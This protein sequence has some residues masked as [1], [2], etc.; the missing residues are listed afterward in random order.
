M[1]DRN[2]ASVTE[3][4]NPGAAPP[5]SPPSICP[6]PVFVIGSPRSG[7]T[8]LAR[9]LAQHS[10]LWASAESD[11]LFF[12]FANGFVERGFDRAMEIPGQR[13]LRVE[14][15][16]REEFLA[17]LGIGINALMTS[18]SEGRRWLDHTPRYAL[19]V[20]TL[21][22]VFPSASFLHILRDGRE[23]VHSMLNF[24]NAVPEPSVK[25]FLREDVP[26]ATDLRAACG[27]WSEHVEAA[28]KF[29]DKHPD[30]A[31]TVRFEDLV[32]APQATFRTVHEFLGIPDEEAPTR[33]FATTRIN[34]SFDD[35]VRL[36]AGELWETW[37]DE[38]RNA[39][40]EV[41][42]ATMLRCGYAKPDDAASGPGADRRRAL[43]GQ[44]RGLMSPPDYARLVAQV[45]DVVESA[46]RRDAEVL[47]AARGDDGFLDFDGRRGWHFPRDPDGTY[48]GQYPADS[49]A[50][51]AQLEELREEGA[52]HLVL[53]QT[54]FWWLDYYEGLKL[55][56]DST[57]RRIR[58]DEDVIVYDL[59][60]SGRS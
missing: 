6:N 44:R 18:R 31:L 4:A 60:S 30:R 48:S 58:E 26:W 34:S 51:I 2:G 52:T 37:E 9:S 57:Y 11:V 54:A 16:S 20:E 8:V 40:T 33:F 14:D 29:R 12:L 32:A 17:Y 24:A 21:A 45:R 23:V 19:I 3:T 1:T 56:L 35:G 25:R 5:A 42:G 38:R 55:H 47:V 53:P 10:E 39:F 27:E 46:V 41:A 7:T 28:V 59:A 13:W 50:A 36:S 49:A 22:E 15:V 43:S